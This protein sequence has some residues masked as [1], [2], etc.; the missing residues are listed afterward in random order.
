MSNSPI[1]KYLLYYFKMT[2]FIK[3]RMLLFL[4]VFWGIFLVSFKV[5]AL[6]VSWPPSPVGTQLTPTST[7]SIFVKYLYEWGIALGGLAAFIALVIAG[8]LYLTSVGDPGRMKEAKEKALWAIGGLVLLLAAWLILNAI[9]PQ[10]TQLPTELVGE[11]KIEPIEIKVGPIKLG[12]KPC[13]SITLYSD[14]KCADK[15]TTIEK[16][17]KKNLPGKVCPHTGILIEAPQPASARA[18]GKKGAMCYLKLFPRGG[19]RDDFIQTTVS[20]QCLDLT[21]LINVDIRC[22]RVG[23][24]KF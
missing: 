6:E 18:S 14:T 22:A 10:L 20:T 1:D 7:L 16:D 3:N 23:G 19:C 17:K 4:F 5:L 21:H 12:I 9:N 8:F 2:K 15:I 11:L 13:Q 24:V